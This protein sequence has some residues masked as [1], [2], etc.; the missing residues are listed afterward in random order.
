MSPHAD[1]HSALG[2]VRLVLHRIASD[3]VL[4][5]CSE[6]LGHVLQVVRAESANQAWGICGESRPAGGH[7]QVPICGGLES[8]FKDGGLVFGSRASEPAAYGT[9][10]DTQSGK[11]NTRAP[12]RTISRLETVAPSPSCAANQAADLDN[13][14]GFCKR[15]VHV[16]A[17][18][19]VEEMRSGWPIRA[20]VRAT[21]DSS[22]VVVHQ[23]RVGWAKDML[24]FWVSQPI[25]RSTSTRH[26]G[27]GFWG[28]PLRDVV[29]AEDME[30]RWERYR[31][32]IPR[33]WL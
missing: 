21:C 16:P 29:N 9:A 30:R 11:V 2:S 31:E 15:F 8:E 13:V 5:G 14:A 26:S 24:D 27:F 32:Y 20:A 7:Q 3:E 22:V 10:G 4:C 18:I 25:N 28:A 33:A 1:V 12:W 19:C 17:F 6:E 23:S